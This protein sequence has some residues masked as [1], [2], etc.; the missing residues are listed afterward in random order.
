MM[1]GRWRH[2]QKIPAEQ[3]AI[4]GVNI[5]ALRLRNRWTQADLGELMDWPSTSTEGNGPVGPC[6]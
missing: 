6:R 5:R 2:V 4:V 3:A 1:E